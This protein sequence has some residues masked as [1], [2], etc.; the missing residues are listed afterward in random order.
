MDPLFDIGHLVQRKNQPESTGVVRQR[1]LNSQ[2]E[3]WEYVVQFGAERVGV[4]EEMLQRL[5]EV[6]SPWDALA[7]GQ[8]S[9]REHFI[10]ALTFERL[11]HPPARIAHS[12]ATARTRFYPYQFK[13][14]L[15]FLEH[16]G[17]RLLIADDVGL[18]KTIEAGYI[19]RELD[20]HRPAE[21]V[22]VVVP[23]RL[24]T[25]W[26][27]E[28]ET[29]FDERFEK[30]KGRDLLDQAHRMAAGQELDSF[31]W[32]VSYESV[33]SAAIR[34][35]LE[36]TQLPIDV[37]I[38]DE[39][40]R[41][42]NP[43]SLQHQVGAV[44]SAC[45][46]AAIFLSATPVMNRL[47]D[48]WHLLRLLSP[49][50]FAVWEVFRERI[51]T[52]RFILAAQR[53]LGSTPPQF[54]EAKIQVSRFADAIRTA[55]P[56]QNEF[57]NSVL[58]RLERHVS[59]TR[60]KIELQADIGR[61]SPVG[62]VISRTRKADAILER[63][64]RVAHWQHVELSPIETE[65]YQSV[66][67][68]CREAG[69]GGS[70]AWG[71]EMALLMAYRAVA[72]C[73]PAAIDYFADKLQTTGV[74]DMDDF[75][76]EGDSLGEEA[77]PWSG[78]VRRRFM[79]IVDL[80]RSATPPDSKLLI[81]EEILA[82]LWKDDD[83][84]DRPRRKVVVFSYFR[85]TLNYLTRKL[86][87]RGVANRMI[88]GGVAIPD[89]EKAITEFLKRQDIRVLLTSEVG[90]EGIDLIEACVVV[91]YDLPWNP[92]VVEQRIGRV[93]R[94]GQVAKRVIVRNLVVKGSVEERVL[95]RLL[96]KIAVFLETVGDLEPIVGEQIEKLTAQALRGELTEE[97]ID[98]RIEN[99]SAVLD[100]ARLD[101]VEVLTEADGLLA[102]DQALVDEIQALIGERRVPAED[103]VFLFLNRFLRQ[104]YPGSQ[105]PVEAIT[106]VVT[107]QFSNEL[108][109][110]M[111]SCG[112]VVG[113]DI[114]D[115]GRRICSSA[116]DVTLS[117]DAAYRRPSAQLIHLQHPLSRFSVHK[118]KQDQTLIQ[119]AFSLRAPVDGLNAGRYGFLIAS[120]DIQ[121]D[122]PA[123]RLVCIVA[124]RDSD[125]VLS[126]PDITTPI[127]VAM[128]RSG[129]DFTHD[130]IG[131]DEVA[132]LESR[133]QQGLQTI[134][135]EWEQRESSLDKARQE[136]LRT[137]QLS[138]LQFRLKRAVERLDHLRNSGAAEFP[139]R[140]A[141]AKLAIAAKEERQFTS[142]PSVSTWRGIAHREL[143]VGLLYATHN[144][145]NG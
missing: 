119:T 55:A 42:R 112:Y 144:E 68:L 145:T 76:E 25:K 133:L 82:D 1:R 103:E 12:F 141:E 86:A 47:E 130:R 113:T 5:V 59:S 125:I 28:L 116:I 71:F 100:R 111:Q 74:L 64:E 14:L 19:L 81:L 49:E 87:S 132:C 104:F 10:A 48:L 138:V 63:P 9:G 41:L 92:M 37:L 139:I 120:V 35:V 33:R 46:D 105:L 50:E 22:L 7:S 23:A 106:D 94:I 72:S 69:I 53:F 79:E 95:S 32:I 121:S 75:E 110:D 29:R 18:G 26:K 142:T 15:K 38:V 70:S 11:V 91:N 16:P 30:V 54:D 66:A 34:E 107:V 129:D 108:G 67:A 21:R 61:L 56:Q 89:R 143:A 126:A 20:A 131:A 128:L 127:L 17:K 31:R 137:A 73:I 123:T 60:E 83:D 2:L 109:L 43:D 99:Q 96:S 93:D 62:H 134:L 85:G 114:I 52:N 24:A 36:R 140:M 58:N 65:I 80:Y 27:A 51:E 40:H 4:P 45:S 124:S 97:E 101:A 57:L 117:R 90:G 44:L 8:F 115:F 118:L 122:R 78:S 135:A 88:H 3:R 13:P 77:S 39:A 102:A 136:R 6:V 84:H 98:R